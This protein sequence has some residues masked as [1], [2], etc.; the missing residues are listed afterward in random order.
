[1]EWRDRFGPG[2][3]AQALGGNAEAVARRILDGS[4]IE[5]H[6]AGRLCQRQVRE[7]LELDYSLTGRFLPE[8]RVLVNC[9]ATDL[10]MDRAVLAGKFTPSPA[11][12]S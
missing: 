5:S 2:P 11:G 4:A 3:V 6:R 8:S 9:R 1:M 10:E 12:G 7:R